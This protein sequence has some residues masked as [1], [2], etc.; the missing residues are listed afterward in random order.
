MT[1]FFLPLLSNMTSWIKFGT[2]K[3][4][5]AEKVHIP[6]WTCAA[7][8][9]LLPTHSFGVKDLIDGKKSVTFL[10]LKLFLKIRNQLMNPAENLNFRRFRLMK[11]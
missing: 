9:A 5:A 2:L 3:S 10:N 6:L 7:I 8:N 1:G 4:M 11:K